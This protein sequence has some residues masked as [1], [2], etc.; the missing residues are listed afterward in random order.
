MTE[1]VKEVQ[2]VFKGSTG[3]CLPTK[4]YTAL[5]EGAATP[6]HQNV[7]RD[8]AQRQCWELSAKVS[9]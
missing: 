7:L 6:G 2:L 3:T 9:A 1:K 5:Y 8:Q 4:E